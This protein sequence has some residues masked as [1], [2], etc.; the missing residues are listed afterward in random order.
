[1]KSAASFIVLA[2]CCIISAPLV[3][4]SVMLPHDLARKSGFSP[5]GSFG[6]RTISGGSNW[7]N[8]NNSLLSSRRRASSVTAMAI[9]GDGIAEQ[10]VVGGFANFLQIY[11]FILTGRILLSWVP[12]AQGI[13]ALQPLFAITDPFLNLFRGVI[14]PIFGLDIS[15]IGAFILLN[16][17]TNSTMAVGAEIPKEH[18]QQQQQLNHKNKAFLQRKKQMTAMMMSMSSA[19][20][21]EAAIKKKQRS[22][23]LMGAAS[24]TSSKKW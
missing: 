16:V 9:P 1:M 20:I 4:A 10:I 22:A 2:L 13:G 14:P 17:L 8:K 19:N 12:Q 11:N 6:A 15:P 3:S 24:Y 5:R 7:K 21:K 23:S 18:E